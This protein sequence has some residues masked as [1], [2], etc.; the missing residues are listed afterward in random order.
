MLTMNVVNRKGTIENIV[1]S[2]KIL[3][4]VSNT[5]K[6]AT[7]TMVSAPAYMVIAHF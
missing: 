4:E 7:A 6:G 3:K 2:D 5:A 1:L